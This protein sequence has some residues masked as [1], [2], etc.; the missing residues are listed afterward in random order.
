MRVKLRW[1]NLLLQPI[2]PLARFTRPVAV[3]ELGAVGPSEDE[4]F[5]P[6]VGGLVWKAERERGEAAGSW[7]KESPRERDAGSFSQTT[8]LWMRDVEAG[9][10]DEGVGKGRA[11]SP[12]HVGGKGGLRLAGRRRESLTQAEKERGEHLAGSRP[13]GG[14]SGRRMR[15]G[16][17]AKAG[18]GGGQSSRSPCR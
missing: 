7:W 4:G 1:P 10:A 15:A 14:P 8:G 9:H 12:A 17:A 5:S 13:K 18:T 11:I 2:V 6:A 16:R 3:V